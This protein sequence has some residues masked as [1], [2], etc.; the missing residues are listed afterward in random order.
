VRGN[1][2]IDAHDA[3]RRLRNVLARLRMKATRSASCELRDDIAEVFD[4]EEA[5]AER[6]LERL[7]HL[8]V[9]EAAIA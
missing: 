4:E 3:T 6:E 5:L 8:A 2:V 1:T 7:L 9:G